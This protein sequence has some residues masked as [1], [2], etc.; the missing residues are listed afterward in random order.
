MR[1]RRAPPRATAAKK[2]YFLSRSLWRCTGTNVIDYIVASFVTRTADE[3][4]LERGQRRQRR[5]DLK[6]REQVRWTLE[7]DHGHGVRLIAMVSVCNILA[8]VHRAVIFSPLD[9]NADRKIVLAGNVNFRIRIHHG[10]A[11]LANHGS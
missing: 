2:S 10:R 7:R 4:L 1:A 9:R 5:G 11:F 6:S 8:N 3:D